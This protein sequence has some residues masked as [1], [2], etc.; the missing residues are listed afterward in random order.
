MATG[1]LL[2]GAWMTSKW[3]QMLRV[4][5]AAAQCCASW[6]HRRRWIRAWPRSLRRSCNVSLVGSRISQTLRLLSRQAL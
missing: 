2:T 1:V 3:V 5:L 6:V 4:Y